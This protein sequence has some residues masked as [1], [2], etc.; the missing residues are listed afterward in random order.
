VGE[1]DE[2]LILGAVELFRVLP[3]RSF[4][5]HERLP[6]RLEGF[7]SREVLGEASGID[8]LTVLEVGARIDQHVLEGAV[9]RA[10][11]GLIPANHLAPGQP[12][13]DIRAGGPVRME[14]RY[15]APDVFVGGVAKK[16]QLG[17]VGLQNGA[18]GAHQMERNRPVFEEIL[19]IKLGR[20]LAHTRM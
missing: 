17:P 9:L 15:V 13:Q 6:L 11:A 18:V 20:W 5:G 4:A 2:K 14:V 8:E 19:E 10:Q 16:L 7:L 12:A 3:S 1:R